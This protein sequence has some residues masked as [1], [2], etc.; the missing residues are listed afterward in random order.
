MIKSKKFK[1][2][3][4]PLAL[5]PLFS[6]TVLAGCSSD[7]DDDGD[8]NGD[9]DIIV[10]E[11]DANGNGIPDE[12]ETTDP[13]L[14]TNGN[15]IADEFET[16]ADGSF[17]DENGN[18]VDDS[19]ENLD[20]DAGDGDDDAGDG[21]D[22]TDAGDGD[23]DT[24]GV[25]LTELDQLG[26]LNDIP[27]GNPRIG[28][29]DLSWDGSALS[30]QVNIESLPENV[31]PTSGFINTGIAASGFSQPGVMLNSDGI[32]TYFVP[33]GLG[34]DMAS[35]IADNILSGNLFINV[36][37]SDG[38]TATGIILLEG[39]EPTFV[40]LNAGNTVPAGTEF[41]VATGFINVNT[42]TGDF[43]AVVNVDI[44]V[45]DVDAD[46]NPEFASAVNIQRGA[47]DENGDT[48]FALENTGNSITWTARGIFSAADLEDVLDGNSF[49]NVARSDGSNFLR[50]QI[51]VP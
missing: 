41:S 51:I 47:A 15:G 43:T 2:N 35:I 21:D 36:E 32:P 26:P 39:V 46:G 42:V 40:N 25:D 10:T 9:G 48:I 1:Q 19:F 22:D 33:N 30:G 4:L 13:A 38:N 28:T 20:G 11:G 6:L 5:V 31:S 18:G 50:G 49:F 27:V 45:E 29:A 17:T 3:W 37:L 7:D 8:G 12:F 16:A 14:D 44:N 34:Q 23:D 24:G